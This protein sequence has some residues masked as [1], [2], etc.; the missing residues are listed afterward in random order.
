MDVKAGLALILGA[1]ITFDFSMLR[2]NHFSLHIPLFTDRSLLFDR[3]GIV[4]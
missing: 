4:L 3:I 1:L 2:I